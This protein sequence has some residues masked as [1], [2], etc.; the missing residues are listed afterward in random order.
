VRLVV[1]RTKHTAEF[2]GAGAF[3][4]ARALR[5]CRPSDIRIDITSLSVEHAAGRLVASLFQ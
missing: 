3:M 2:G 4:I 5:R 1:R